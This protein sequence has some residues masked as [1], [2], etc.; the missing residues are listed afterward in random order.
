MPLNDDQILALSPHLVLTKIMGKPNLKSITLQQSKHNGNLASA[1]SNLGDGLTG[2]MVI[3]MKTATSATTHPEPFTITTNPDPAPDPDANAASSSATK[4]AKIYKA[5]ALQRKFYSEFIEAEMFLV[6]LTLDLMAEIE[7]K[8]LKHTHTGYGKVTLRQLLD[9]LVT[10]YAAIYQFDLEKNQEKMTARYDLNAPIET[11]FKKITDNVA[12]TELRDEPF[13]SKQIVDT[14]LLCL[15]KTWLFHNHLNDWNQ[16]P[17]PSRNWNTFRVHF[18]KAHRE[19][20][21]NFRLTTGKKFPHANAV[22]TFNPT[23]EHQSDTLEALSN[24]EMSTPENRATVSTLTDTI[25]Q[26]SLELASD[27]V[28]LISSLLDNQKL[29][30]RLL[31]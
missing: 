18:T 25:V 4:I 15:A 12:Y 13:T 11:L 6:K 19:W 16:K 20:K 8:A 14:Y 5:Y 23:A 31:E 22:D 10:T 17:P 1:K 29:L 26:L 27:H 9:H 3:S 24:L 7:Y 30:K 21:A 2:L 28:K